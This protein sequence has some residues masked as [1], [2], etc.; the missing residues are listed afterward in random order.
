LQKA[1]TQVIEKV[2]DALGNV[3]LAINET[4]LMGGQRGFIWIKTRAPTR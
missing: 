2:I 4:S 3:S 1:E